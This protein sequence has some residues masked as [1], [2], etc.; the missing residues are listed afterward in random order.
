MRRFA[1]ATA[2]AALALLGSPLPGTTPAG[3][4]PII[5]DGPAPSLPTADGPAFKPRK[6]A[7]AT[8]APQ[9]P[10]LAGDPRSNIH[11]DTWMTDTYHGAAPLGRDSVTRSA[12][13]ALG[14]CAT[15]AFDRRGR[16]VSVC[17]STLSPPQARI[18]DPETLEVIAS[19]DLPQAPEVG[20]PA[21]YQNFAAGGYFFLDPKDRIWV[22]TKTNHIYVLGQTPDG[23][24]FRLEDD[25]DLSSRL[26]VDTERISSALPD[27]RGRIWVVAK[28]SGKVAVLDTRTRGIR[29]LRLGEPIQ[30][31]FTVGRAGVYIASSKRLYRFGTTRGGAPEIEWKVRYRNDGAV[32]PGQ[33]DAGTGTTPTILKGGYVAITDNADPINVVVYR[34]GLR[35]RGRKRLVCEVPVFAKGASATENSLIGTGRSLIAENNYGY[36][37]PFAPGG[38]QVVTQPGFA[39]VDVRRDGRGC[40]KVWTNREVRAPSAVPKLS[41]RTGLI[42]TYTRPPDP[43]GSQG[44][45]WTAIDFRSGKTAWN[46]YAGSG[47]R[48]NNNY[49]GLGIG[50]DG[51]AYLGVVGG[52]ISL[53]DG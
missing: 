43:G 18:I 5:S 11:N 53:G 27:F 29:L 17:P 49:A 6:V 13:A 41:T 39:R 45:Y 48:F 19:Y 44:Y 1:V 32:K 38:G 35:L 15:M 2:I 51:T 20:K 7:G 50:P 8:R 46:R 42:Y 37:D 52:M 24:G 14:I 47:L 34:T 3:A 9:N 21:A 36:T 12:A 10:H 16:I 4:Q 28:Q 31:S 23:S 40:R 33:A 26:D 22:A 25:Y 30:N